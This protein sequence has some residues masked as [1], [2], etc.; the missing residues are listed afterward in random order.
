MKH[1]YISIYR[2]AQADNRLINLTIYDNSDF[3]IERIEAE[4]LISYRTDPSGTAWRRE[5]LAELIPASND[6]IIVPE[7]AAVIDYNIYERPDRFDLVHRYIVI[8][9]GTKDLTACLFGYYDFASARAVI[10][11]ELLIPQKSTTDQ[12]AAYILKQKVELWGSHNVFR[13][14]ADAISHQLIIDINDK[15]Y[16][17]GIQFVHPSKL[18]LEAMVNQ[19][20]I[21]LMD[22]KIAIHPDCKLLIDTI[23]TGTWKINQ[24]NGKRDFARLNDIGHCDFLAALNYFNR[25]LIKNMNPYASIKPTQTQWSNPYA[26]KQ[27]NQHTALVKALIGPS[28]AFRR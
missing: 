12:I 2:Q 19:L 18:D 14:V 17:H 22:K 23:N 5:F 16:E 7:A 15:L 28:R 27:D 21:S 10:E 24:G 25:A 3:T 26:P 13:S 8:D 20:T 11:K 4:K 1:D 6:L 9:H